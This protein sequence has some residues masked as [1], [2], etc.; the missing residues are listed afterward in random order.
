MGD[1][2]GM[3]ETSTPNCSCRKELG[4]LSTQN[5]ESFCR[6]PGNLEPAGHIP[7]KL[8]KSSNP[9][10]GYPRCPHHALSSVVVS[11]QKNF[12]A[13]D[14]RSIQQHCSCSR[15]AANQQSEQMEC[16]SPSEGGPGGCHQPAPTT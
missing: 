3:G 4:V 11:S 10:N 2:T 8:P 16:K 15:H 7:A 12:I 13:T 1:T 6:A 5:L 14:D 9:Q